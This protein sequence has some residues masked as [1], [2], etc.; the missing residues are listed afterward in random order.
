MT[1]HDNV[2]FF[3]I[4]YEFV[5]LVY[6]TMHDFFTLHDYVSLGLTMYHFVW[7]CMTV[8]DFVWLYVTMHNLYRYVWLW[9]ALYE[10][11]WFFM[12]LYDCALSCVTPFYSGCLFM[13]QY[14]ALLHCIIII[15]IIDICKIKQNTIMIN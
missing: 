1:M 7:L 15:I 12:T 10:Y 14:N 2:Y 6:M 11:F 9:I 8:Y 3:N 4:T 13:I 5:W